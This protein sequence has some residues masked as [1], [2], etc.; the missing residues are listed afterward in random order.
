MRQATLITG[1]GLYPLLKLEAIQYAR[2]ART[3]RDLQENHAADRAAT[4][5]QRRQAEQDEHD[6]MPAF[7]RKRLIIG[8]LI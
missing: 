6:E 5:W 4:F 7:I 2:R 3:E 1:V 8:E